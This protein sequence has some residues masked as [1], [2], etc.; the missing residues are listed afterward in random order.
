[1][2]NFNFENSNFSLY[3]EFEEKWNKIERNKVNNLKK[4]KDLDKIII[5]KVI[6]PLFIL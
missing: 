1:M 4:K 3:K 2:K 5:L 6:I